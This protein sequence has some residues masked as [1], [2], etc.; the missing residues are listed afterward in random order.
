VTPDSKSAPEDKSDITPDVPGHKL[1]VMPGTDSDIMRVHASPEA[2]SGSKPGA[3][4]GAKSGSKPGAPFR[5][6]VRL[7]AWR[8]L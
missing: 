6:Q 3:P 1:D 4:F 5:G 2:K 8:P 7:Q